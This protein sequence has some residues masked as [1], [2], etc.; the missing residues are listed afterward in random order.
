MKD[1]EYARKY[2]N[3]TCRIFGME[4]DT[5]LKLGMLMQGHTAGCITT[6][7][8]NFVKVPQISRHSCLQT[9]RGET[10]IIRQKY[11]R[12]EACGGCCSDPE[13]PPCYH[14]HRPD[15]LGT[16]LMK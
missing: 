2:L 1:F 6:S 13:M 3:T 15:A 11:A 5:I 4:H 10:P 8:L 7:Q 12:S 16:G 9:L 14:M